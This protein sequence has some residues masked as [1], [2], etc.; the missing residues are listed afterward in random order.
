M[1]H[2]ELSDDTFQKE[3][4]DSKNLVLVDFWAPWCMPCQM[5]GP[6][7]EEISSEFGDKV[8]IGK[9]NVDENRQF[10]EK[11]NVMS[12]PNVILFKN[13][14]IVEQFVGVR[15]KDDYLESINKNLEK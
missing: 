9:M 15:S 5:L 13:G 4:L 6:I 1:A 3:V 12:I 2:I 11:Y 7:I 8:K 14:E 10:P